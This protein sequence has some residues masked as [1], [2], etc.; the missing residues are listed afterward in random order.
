MST[1]P[2]QQREVYLC[3]RHEAWHSKTSVPSRPPRRH[4]ACLANELT[5]ELPLKGLMLPP[6]LPGIGFR[7]VSKN[8]A[9]GARIEQR[10]S[11]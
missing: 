8:S 2:S 4:V 10:P 3:Q 11:G 5:L 7:L 1:R 6:G 9:A